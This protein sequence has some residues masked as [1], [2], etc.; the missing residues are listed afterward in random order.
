MSYPKWGR[1]PSS[2]F[3][4]YPSTRPHEP[5]DCSL[6]PVP[7]CGLP[8]AHSWTARSF[9]GQNLLRLL[10]LDRLGAFRLDD[11]RLAITL[12]GVP[13]AQSPDPGRDVLR[14]AILWPAPWVSASARSPPRASRPA[15]APGIPQPNLV[16]HRQPAG[17]GLV[18]CNGFQNPGLDA[19]RPRCRTA[20]S[21]PADRQRRRRD[22]RRL[23]RARRRPGPARRPGGVQ[24][25]LAQHALVYEWS[26]RPPS[27]RAC[28][29]GAGRHREPLIVKLSPDFA[30][31]RARDHSGGARG[32]RPDR[33][34]RQRAP[35][36]RS[37]ACRR[38]P[39]GFPD[40]R[41]SRP[42]WQLPAHARALRRCTRDHRDRRRRHAGQGARRSSTPAPRRA[43]TSP[44]SSPAGRCSPAILER[45]L[46]S[47]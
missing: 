16:R 18:N 7:L 35:G 11:P 30:D 28:S 27:S 8:L 23:R 24:R 20:P 25:L 34:L 19:F 3:A 14:P 13:S 43:A 10:P 32:R 17:P 22:D 9:L 26:T 6:L 42:R 21:G 29:R 1:R 4:C 45:L 44:A 36:R 38:A 15:R 41:S 5:N 39:A 37:G 12:G 31:K 46:A 40:P 33:Q 47:R 2:R